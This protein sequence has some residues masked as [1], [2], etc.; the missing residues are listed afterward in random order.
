MISAAHGVSNRFDDLALQRWEDE[1]G[2]MTPV[3]VERWNTPTA[4]PSEL[5]GPE[6]V[7]PLV[8]NLRPPITDNLANRSRPFRGVSPRWYT[9]LF[10]TVAS[11]INCTDALGVVQ[12][13]N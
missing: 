6:E 1:G 12:F 7:I 5:G 11:S 13:T 8:A 9:P 2:C 4:V 10:R 3:A